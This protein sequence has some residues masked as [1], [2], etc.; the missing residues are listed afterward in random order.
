MMWVG[1]QSQNLNHQTNIKN[2][3]LEIGVGNEKKFEEVGLSLPFY[4]RMSAGRRLVFAST[5]LRPSLL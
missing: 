3:V 2:Q 1:G 5:S 4:C